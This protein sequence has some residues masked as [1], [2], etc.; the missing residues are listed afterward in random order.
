MDIK[1]LNILAPIPHFHTNAIDALIKSPPIVSPSQPIQQQQQEEK[2]HIPTPKAA[3]E[4]EEQQQQNILSNNR[5]SWWG[6]EKIA[7]EEQ[8]DSNTNNNR[9]SY[10]GPFT[11]HTPI[12][13]S[14]FHN[15]NMMDSYFYP[16]SPSTTNN[17]SI[18][19]WQ[20]SNIPPLNIST[21][22]ARPILTS[23]LTTTATITPVTPNII[24]LQV[25]ETS[26][27]AR[28]RSAGTASDFFS[29]IQS[30]P[31]QV[32][33]S[34]EIEE[35]LQSSRSSLSLHELN[36][37]QSLLL[38]QKFVYQSPSVRSQ[39]LSN[40]NPFTPTPTK[41]LMTSPFDD[42]VVE[43][44]ESIIVT[45]KSDSTREERQ[46]NNK[47][48]K[49]SIPPPPVPHQS[50]KPAFPK[51]TR[52]NSFLIKRRQSTTGTPAAAANHNLLLQR[53]KS[54]TSTNMFY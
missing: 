17:S 3:A 18:Q 43:A 30:N 12:P 2:K 19:Q 34:P 44:D 50:T 46:I 27:H 47:P 39:E 13:N 4:D 5:K 6:N 51:Y 40:K 28:S 41:E 16:L 14:P 24:Q 8:E 33:Q 23:S 21:A 45:P 38:T 22:T 31:Y 49:Y 37:G 11:A 54:T 36:T 10:I 53:H 52:T 29:S 1:T 35:P 15:N 42:V 48:N 32:A 26:Q 20:P 7:V 9:H 25:K